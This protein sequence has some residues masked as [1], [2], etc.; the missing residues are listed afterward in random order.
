[1]LTIFAGR[2][3]LAQTVITQKVR[4][5]YVI[6]KSGSYRLGSDLT[7]PLNTNAIEVNVS[8]V[9]ID[10]NGFSIIG[11]P[12]APNVWAISSTS[13]GAVVKGGTL[14]GLCLSSLVEDVVALNCSGDGI[15]VGPNSRVLRSQA[16]GGHNVGIDC[17]T[18][19]GSNC[20]FVDD[21]ANGNS[22]HGIGCS[23]SGCNFA[24][25]TTNGNGGNGLDCNGSGCSFRG[26]DVSDSNTLSGIAALD[27]TSAIS[28]TVLNANSV[29]PF[30]GATSLGNNLCNGAPC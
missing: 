17:A 16:D 11:S 22:L 26:D 14:T 9:T 21:T 23:A 8:G 3:A 7:P 1:M 18:I 25:D 27:H 15:D 19:S 5:P 30:G 28:G 2:S 24:R 20:L 12:T 29:A 10:L 4:F 13:S 6:T